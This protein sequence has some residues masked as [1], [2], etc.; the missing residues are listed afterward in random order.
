MDTN[1]I[2]SALFWKGAPYEVVRS[3]IKGEFQMITSESILKETRDKLADKFKVP[4]SETNE[5]IKIILANSFMVL[6]LHKIDAIKIDPSDNKILECAVFGGANFIV[7][8][9]K[10]LLDLRQYG[11]IKIITPQNFLGILNKKQ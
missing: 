4:L 1:V 7:S 9:D 10:H 3:G 2:I 8:G 11:N 6:P 5:L